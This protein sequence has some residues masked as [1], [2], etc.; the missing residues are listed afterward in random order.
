MIETVVYYTASL[1]HGR[2]KP[3]DRPVPPLRK[4]S[5]SLVQWINSPGPHPNI[6]K[7]FYH[8]FL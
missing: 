4:M 7:L 1:N 3:S 2:V 8:G 5:Y 6:K